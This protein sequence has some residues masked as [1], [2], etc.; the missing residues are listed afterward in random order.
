[1]AFNQ[2]T[3]IPDALPHQPH[4]DVPGELEPGVHPIEPDEGSVP[5]MIPN[6]PEHDRLID[7]A[8]SP[9]QRTGDDR[10]REQMT[11]GFEP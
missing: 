3:T 5:A 9:D 11:G 2:T 1:M 8:E 4:H 6:D 10:R 7:P